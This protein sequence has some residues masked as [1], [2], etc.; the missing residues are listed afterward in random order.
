LTLYFSRVDWAILLQA[1]LL[2]FGPPLL[3]VTVR[4]SRHRI[5]YFIL[6]LVCG[7]LPVFYYLLLELAGKSIGW[8][9]MINPFWLFWQMDRPEVFRPA[10][11]I[12]ILVW[13]VV[14]LIGFLIYYKGTRSGFISPVNDHKGRCLPRIR[15]VDNEVY[16]R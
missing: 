9:V 5:Y 8:L 10:W 4:N 15:A 13:V 6:M 3:L 11:L 2:L 7:A 12:Q 16:P 14:I 1:N